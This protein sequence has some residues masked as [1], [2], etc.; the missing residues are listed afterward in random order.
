[1]AGLSPNHP[2]SDSTVGRALQQVNEFHRLQ[3]CNRIRDFRQK[4]ETDV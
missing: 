3:A 4:I 1:M 2:E